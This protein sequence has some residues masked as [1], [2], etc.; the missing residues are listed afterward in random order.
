MT[1]SEKKPAW[2]SVLYSVSYD[3]L[4]SVLYSVSYDEF[5]ALTVN[6]T[7]RTDD[8]EERSTGPR[9][10]PHGS[11][12]LHYVYVYQITTFRSLNYFLSWPSERWLYYRISTFNNTSVCVVSY[13]WRHG[14][15]SGVLLTGVEACCRV[16]RL[17]PPAMP[18]SRQLGGSEALTCLHVNLAFIRNKSVHE[19]G[20]R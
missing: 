19:N 17:L 10:R 3:E 9:W 14:S 12:T 8:T 4:K 6:C 2:K 5:N 18:P 20:P 7:S 1:F 13:L 11:S 15:G 16:S